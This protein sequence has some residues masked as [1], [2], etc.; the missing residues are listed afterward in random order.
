MAYVLVQNGAV[1]EYYVAVPQGWTFSDGSRTGNFDALSDQERID[2]AS[3]YPLVDEG[4]SPSAF[5]EAGTPSFRIEPTRVVRV[6]S[7]KTA[8]SDQIIGLKL[9]EIAN[10]ARARVESGKV[11]VFAREWA[12]NDEHLVRLSGM[13]EAVTEGEP[14]PLTWIAANGRPWRV[15]NIEAL[16]ALRKEIVR[17]RAR[18]AAKSA[19]H[20]KGIDDLRAT[21]A[22]LPTYATSVGWP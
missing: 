20:V 9:E 2:R 6:L 19:E 4:P 21:P 17:W 12:T 18:V 16:I 1:T 14:L 3:F 13:I 7:V 22:L 15:P 5:Q 11:V 8:T 10:E